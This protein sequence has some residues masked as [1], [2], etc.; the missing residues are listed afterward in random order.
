VALQIE[1]NL[2]V[3]GLHKPRG[4]AQGLLIEA[5]CVDGM[6]KLPCSIKRR[7]REQAS[8]WMPERSRLNVVEMRLDTDYRKQSRRTTTRC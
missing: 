7:D 6:N 4:Y 8:N 2:T 1:G 5:E 3:S